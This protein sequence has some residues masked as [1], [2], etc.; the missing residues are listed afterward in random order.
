MN[1]E[2]STPP[3]DAPR[4]PA[5]KSKNYLPEILVTGLVLAGGGW[6]WSQN[7]AP[8][9]PF[10]PE[11]KAAQAQEAPAQDAPPANWKVAPQAEV[12]ATRK[13]IVAQ[14]EAFK[15]DDYKEAE[16]YQAAGLRD[17]FGSTEQFRQV[18]K[19]NYPQ[20]ANYKEIRWGAA[21]IDGPML[22]IQ[23]VI[24]GQ[25]GAE[26]AALYS[27]IKE[28]VGT[29]DKEQLEYRVSG[30]SGGSMEIADTQVV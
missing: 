4:K 2:N 30:V 5:R 27:M 21:R 10:A 6:F 18:I 24:V 26:I 15:A 14:L 23:I 8:A 12:E 3:S 9:I 17:S 13:V 22:Q 7:L 20:F 29:K 16:K 25:D 19:T 11:M 1:S 28:N